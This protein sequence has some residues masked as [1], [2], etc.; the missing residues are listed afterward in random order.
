[1]NRH[2]SWFSWLYW[3]LNNMTWTSQTI[4]LQV[5]HSTRGNYSGVSPFFILYSS[6]TPYWKHLPWNIYGLNILFYIRYYQ[7]KWLI[8][9]HTYYVEY[10]DNSIK[11]KFMKAFETKRVRYSYVSYGVNSLRLED[12]LLKMSI[13]YLLIIIELEFQNY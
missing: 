3:L 11:D 12:I 9:F 7:S 2:I 5:T 4:N 10:V 8:S 13:Q 1:M 6:N